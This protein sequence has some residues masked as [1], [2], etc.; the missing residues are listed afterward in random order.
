ML[1]KVLDGCA[2]N[3]GK[4]VFASAGTNVGLTMTVTDTTTGAQ[5]IYQNADLNP[6]QPIQDTSAF[7]T[8]P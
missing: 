3:G 7:A 4:W 6:A 1:V 5:K 8:C 2:V